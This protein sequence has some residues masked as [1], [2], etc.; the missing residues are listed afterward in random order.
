MG[1]VSRYYV[2]DQLELLDDIISCPYQDH[3][4]NQP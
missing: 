1:E 2:K 3:P 4:V